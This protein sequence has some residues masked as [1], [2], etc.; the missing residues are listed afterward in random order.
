L[1]KKNSFLWRDEPKVAFEELKKAVINPLV[2]ID[3][4]QLFIVECNSL[5]KCI[6]AVL[7]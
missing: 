1:L 6:G 5:G 4:S 2:L 3:F 7:M